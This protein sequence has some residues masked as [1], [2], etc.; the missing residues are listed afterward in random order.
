[1]TG[2]EI[3]NPESGY[4]APSN[5]SCKSRLCPATV[6]VRRQHEIEGFAR[7]AGVK[8]ATPEG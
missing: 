3:A 6:L 7:V 1:M 2:Q 4:G 5:K 8:S